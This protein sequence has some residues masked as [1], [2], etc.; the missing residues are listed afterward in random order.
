MVRI[1]VKRLRSQQDRLL[2]IRPRPRCC[3]LLMTLCEEASAPAYATRWRRRD[4]IGK[5]LSS[6]LA[7]KI[8]YGLQPD[9]FTN[10]PQ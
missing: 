5:L 4:L 10:S 1:T 7:H 2:N 3:E 8:I 9:H 6:G